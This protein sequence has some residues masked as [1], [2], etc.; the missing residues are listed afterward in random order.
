MATP[1][2]LARINAEMTMQEVADK[3]GMHVQTYSKFEKEPE[4]MSVED[5]KKFAKVVNQK[6]SD[7]F[8]GSDS[9]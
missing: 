6:C 9:N 5:A 2:K 7:I 8:F 1:M 4:L 3:L